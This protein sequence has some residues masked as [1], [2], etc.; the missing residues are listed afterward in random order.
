ML[1]ML[2][3]EEKKENKTS[4]PATC[5]SNQVTALVRWQPEHG[6]FQD[7]LELSFGKKS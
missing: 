1:L 7:F 2:N 6:K 5:R 3:M 4:N